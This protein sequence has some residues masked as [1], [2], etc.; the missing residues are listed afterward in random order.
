MVFYPSV[1]M[2]RETLP[3]VKYQ[4]LITQYDFSQVLDYIVKDY[5]GSDYP[6]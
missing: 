2:Y 1:K 3:R 4:L 5:T 6:G